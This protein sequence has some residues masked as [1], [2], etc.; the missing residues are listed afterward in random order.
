MKLIGN[1]NITDPFVNLALDEFAVRNLNP[2]DEYVILYINDPSIIIGKHQN[3]LEEAD[4]DFLR[5]NKIKLARRISGG[6]TVYHDHG[7]LNFGF[8]TKFAQN[9]IHNFRYFTKP[10]LQALKKIGINAALNDRNDIMIDGKKISGN[11]QFTNTKIMLSHGTLL[12]DSDLELL[13]RSLKS[14]AN[15]TESRS[16]KSVRSKVS[17]IKNYL[18]NDF[19]IEDLKNEI[20]ISL[21]ENFS[22]QKFELSDI[23]WDSVFE[24]AEKKYNNCEWVLERTPEF[25]IRKTIFYNE[26]NY[27]A[28][29]TIKDGMTSDILLNDLPGREILKEIE[30]IY[31]NK[32][33]PFYNFS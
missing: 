12:F 32:P 22:L 11:A 9:R 33:F 24:L 25:K 16:I 31:L 18:K 1:R 26:N 2:D 13:S 4:L 8:I 29:L 20:I 5:E 15:I 21:N 3:P 7:N 30:K 10:V 27:E 23:Q 28:L 19:G 14:K 17:N 6:G